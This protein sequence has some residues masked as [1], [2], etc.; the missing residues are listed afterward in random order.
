MG[1]K[2]LAP[3]LRAEQSRPNSALTSSS[4]F[5]ARFHSSRSP[6]RWRLNVRTLLLCAV[7]FIAAG[8]ALSP[9]SYAARQ[10]AVG[11]GIIPLDADG[12]LNGVDMSVSGITGTLTVGV[13][14]GPEMDIFTANNPALPGLVA[15]STGAS[16]QGNVQFNSSSTVYGDIGVTQ[17]GGPFL[18]NISGGNDG[19]VVNFQG[20]VFATTLDVVGTGAMNFNNGAINVVATN[21]AADGT[22]YLSSNTTVIG[23]LTTTAGAQ[24]GTLVLSDG[25]VLD[26][27]V[28]GAIGLKSIN[29]VGGNNTAGVSAT[30]TGAVDAYTFSLGTDTLLIGGALTIANTG[31][32]GVINTTL[33]SPTVYGN[34]RPLGATNLGPTLA[35][36]VLVPGTANIPVGSIFNIV[37]SQS[38]TTQSGSDGSVL[39]I[40]IQDPTNPLYT[41]VAVP[42]AGTVAGLVAIKTTGIPLTTPVAPPPGVVL[43]PAAPIAAVIVPV[44]IALPGTGDLGTVVLPAINALTTADAV[45]D[46]L[47]QL[48]PST[49]GLVAP[50]VT[51]Q[52]ARMFQA[53][54]L[55]FMDSPECAVTGQPDRDAPP[56]ERD[57][58]YCRADDPRGALW[59][60]GTGYFGDQRTHGASAGYDSDILGI[61]FGYDGPVGSGTRLGLAMGYAKSKIDEKA[62]ISRTDIETFEGMAYASHQEGA[63]FIYGDISFAVNN[64]T[65]LRH[66]AFPGIDR[67]ARADYR[68]AAYSAFGTTGY[69]FATEAV[70]ITPFASLQYSNVRI[71]GYRES[72]AVDLNL[73]VRER[74]YDFLES[75]L[76]VQLAHDFATDGGDYVPEAHF[77]WLHE[78]QNPSLGVRAAFSAPGSLAFTTPG[79]P[80]AD[81]TLNAGGGVT[82]LSCGCETNTWALKGV[83]DYYWSAGHYSAQQGT[84]K[85]TVQF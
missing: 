25:S 12:A 84:L 60:K 44:L 23:A 77:K 61:M 58:T 10:A 83:Y 74:S 20:P 75:G 30:I 45:V 68:G 63:W 15:I 50:L 76:G 55:E 40:T 35:I 56:E 27:A 4:T 65:G 18:L 34:I 54:A 82:F 28:G 2:M 37:Q 36:N 79:E 31:A 73:N 8:T 29:V 62:S 81:N 5:P 80:S 71:A 72:G 78:I 17:P 22:I 69:H 42:E 38:G 46:A 3:T 43:P 11:P 13:V 53:Q 7:S 24:T 64:Y 19:T 9:P 85:L 6:A 41:F 1:T 32:G 49:S 39:N 59:M 26:G 48:Q 16:S 52:G 51:F 70:T 66:I 21:F 33:A 47:L 14:G 57:S 67:I